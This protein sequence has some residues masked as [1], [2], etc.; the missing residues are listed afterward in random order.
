MKI[1]ILCLVWMMQLGVIGVK[2]ENLSTL[3]ER[4][5]I[6]ENELVLYE[7]ELEQL[8]QKEDVSLTDYKELATKTWQLKE[9]LEELDEQ[10]QI[11]Y[12]Q[13]K[14]NQVS[15]QIT[16]HLE[17]YDGPEPDRT[18][19]NGE[20]LAFQAAVPTYGSK[21]SPGIGYLIWQLYDDQ[22]QPI[23]GVQK[24]RQINENGE[25]EQARFRFQINNLPNGT[26]TVA[27]LHQLEGGENTKT[28]LRQ[29]T[30]EE[31]ISINRLVVSNNA[32]AA[33]HQA[34]L[35]V[36]DAPYGFVYFNLAESIQEV[37]VNLQMVDFSSG[38]IIANE[39]VMRERNDAGEEQRVGM[40][41]EPG[42]IKAGQK[43]TFNAILNTPNGLQK[44]KSTNFEIKQQEKIAKVDQ[45]K[46]DE[47]DSLWEDYWENGN[48]MEKGY[49]KNGKKDGIWEEYFEDNGNLQYMTTYQDGKRNGLFE[50][51]HYNGALDR[52][53]NYK[54]GEQD[55]L[56]V[57]NYSNGQLLDKLFFK[58]G[59]L[60]G[61]GESYHKNGN[62][63]HKFNAKD[64]KYHG[65]AQWYYE[66]GQLMKKVNFI[67]GKK[68]GIEE[69]YLENGI[70]GE[71][72]VYKNGIKQN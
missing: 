60:D 50:S 24:V 5:V 18:V 53:G 17:N 9:V 19:A 54:N 21:D 11:L 63:S 49:Y 20:I 70:L 61:P 56:W 42:Y 71:K 23:E 66:N 8:T 40:R 45:K 12:T 33:N 34:V 32:E 51:Y 10:L 65:M 46:N 31:P 64:G 55:G 48:L 37:N 62:L 58:N 39:E 43:I 7:Q 26:Y 72:T 27:L 44:I 15:F 4:Y 57:E 29:F 30:V 22:D 16:A 38:K 35:L 13:A 1:I 68:D 2:A 14:D 69:Y 41:L 6:V 25:Q 52:K 67:N 36:D 3:L 59:D 47:Q 28:A